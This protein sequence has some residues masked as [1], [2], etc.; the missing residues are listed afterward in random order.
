M[1]K[2]AIAAMF[3]VASSAASAFDVDGFHS[4]MTPADVA[5]IA[6]RQGLEMWQTQSAGTYATGI[7]SQYRIDGSFAF[8]PATGLVAYSHDLDPDNAYLPAVERTLAAWGQPTV[9]VRRGV[10]PGPGGGDIATIDMV[11]KRADGTQLMISSN[12]EGRDGSGV[13]RYK[14][15]ASISYVDRSRV[16]PGK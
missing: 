10:W 11:W 2:A 13:L 14:R 7:R 4:G 6:Q 16:C 15:S 12:P 9:S 3:L 1:K 5:A 8:C